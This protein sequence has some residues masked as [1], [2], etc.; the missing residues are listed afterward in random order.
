LHPNVTEAFIG[1]S[2]NPLV[3]TS[4]LVLN[5]IGGL[6]FG[7]LFWTFGLDGAVLAHFLAD[8][9]KLPLIPLENARYLS[10]TSVIVL[11]LF[12]LIWAWMTLILKHRS[13]ATIVN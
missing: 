4:T 12:A 8:A 1:L 6:V 3:V 10:A 13:P 2:L 7:W 5:G 11:G 9:I